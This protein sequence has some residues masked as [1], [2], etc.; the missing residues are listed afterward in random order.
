MELIEN[1]VEL[2]KVLHSNYD[3]GFF[4]SES[5]MDMFL[6]KAKFIVINKVE[7]DSCFAY[8]VL[9]DEIILFVTLHKNSKSVFNISQKIHLKNEPLTLEIL[10]QNFNE[11]MI[12]PIRIES[13]KIPYQ[14]FYFEH[15]TRLVYFEDGLLKVE[16]ISYEGKDNA[17]MTTYE[18]SYINKKN[19]F[20]CY[21]FIYFIND[22]LSFFDLNIDGDVIVNMKSVIEVIPFLSN[23]TIGNH[24]ELLKQVT[25]S[26]KQL[27]LMMII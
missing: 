7:G 19:D 27:L 18:Y 26:E 6:L 8:R 10:H 14:I 2:E 12:K 24:L 4:E 23:V 17:K 15:N 20:L 1:L 3:N 25:T 22:K 21:S 11:T 16:D 9:S 13:H 5:A